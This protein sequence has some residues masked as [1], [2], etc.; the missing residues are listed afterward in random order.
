MGKNI[1]S[2]QKMEW[3]NEEGFNYWLPII[4]KQHE[5]AFKTLPSHKAGNQQVVP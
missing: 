3:E 5:V 4:Y 1:T 2:L